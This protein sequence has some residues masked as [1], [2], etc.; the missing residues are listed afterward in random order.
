MSCEEL[1]E[2]FIIQWHAY[3]VPGSPPVRCGCQLI[4]FTLTTNNL[5][6]QEIQI[7]RSVKDRDG[8]MLM[9]TALFADGCQSF[10]HLTI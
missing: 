8:S 4:M 2:P 10:A 9:A 1:T 7:A 6:Q 3:W 5:C